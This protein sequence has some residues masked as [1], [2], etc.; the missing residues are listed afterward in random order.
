MAY[1]DFK[2]LN[3]IIDADNVLHDKSFDIAKD[4][5]YGA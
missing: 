3:R 5:K 2:D 4:L 1:W